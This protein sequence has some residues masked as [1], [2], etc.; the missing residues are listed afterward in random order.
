MTLR[1]GRV[2]NARQRNQSP[3]QVQED[4]RA[5]IVQQCQTGRGLGSAN[6]NIGECP[7]AWSLGRRGS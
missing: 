3:D 5:L 4:N 1:T 2:R 6:R 7:E